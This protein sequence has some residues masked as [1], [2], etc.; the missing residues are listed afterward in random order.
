MHLQHGDL[1]HRVLGLWVWTSARWYSSGGLSCVH[2][3]QMSGAHIKVP[4]CSPLEH[5]GGSMQVIAGKWLPA[6][7][8]GC[9]LKSVWMLMWQHS[10]PPL[11]PSTRWHRFLPK[12]SE[13][14]MPTAVAGSPQL[15]K[16]G[17]SVLGTSEI[18]IYPSL[19]HKH[20]TRPSKYFILSHSLPP[21]SPVGHHV[22]F[23]QLLFYLAILQNV[24]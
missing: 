5:G 21:C 10:W 6:Q 16:P 20:T 11:L 23:P 18:S 12:P 19:T 22:G 7:V 3:L 14:G 24:R 2:S 4:C 1:K 9:C 13:P 17:L 8:C 15:G